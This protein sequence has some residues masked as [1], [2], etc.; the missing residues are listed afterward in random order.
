MHACDRLALAGGGFVIKDDPVVAEHLAEYFLAGSVAPLGELDVVEYIRIAGHH[1][2]L[3]I[4]LVG[5]VGTADTEPVGDFLDGDMRDGFLGRGIVLEILPGGGAALVAQLE[6]AFGIFFGS[7]FHG[8]VDAR[9][10]AVTDQRQFFLELVV[11]IHVAI[12][13]ERGNSQCIQGKGQEKCQLSHVTQS[14]K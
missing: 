7:R 3:G 1:A 5:P 12:V 14:N 2:D 9:Q 11:N 8:H 10:V 4:D 13:G 6:P